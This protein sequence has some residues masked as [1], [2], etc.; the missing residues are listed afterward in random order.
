MNIEK[1]Q[2]ILQRA[3]KRFKEVQDAESYTRE[4]M[5]KDIDAFYADLWE[6]VAPGWRANFEGY[7]RPVLETGLLNPLVRRVSND[8]LSMEPEIKSYARNQE[9][10]KKAEYRQGL[11]RHI[12]YNSDAQ[13]AINVAVKSAAICGRGHFRLLTDYVDNETA[14]QSI[15]FEPIKNSMN[16]YMSPRRKGYDYT[17]CEYAF[18][19]DR[20]AKDEFKET[21]P[22]AN[23]MNWESNEVNGWYSSDDLMIAEYFECD[24]IN[25]TILFY[26]DGSKLFLDEVE[27]EKREEAK[28]L[29]EQTRDVKYKIVKW[30]K[31]TGNSILEQKTIIGDKIPI[32]TIIAD[33]GETST[34]QMVISGLVRKAKSSAWLYDLDCSLEAEVLN[35]NSITHW[36]ADPDQIAGAEHLYAS[37]NKVPRSYLPAKTIIK[38][39]ILVPRP[40]RVQPVPVSSALYSAKMS[41]KADMYASSGISEERMGYESN[42]QSGRAV[43]ARS[44][45]SKMTNSN[46]TRSVNKALTYAGKIINKWIPFTHD[47]N[48]IIQILDIENKPGVIE[49]NGRGEKSI[50]L[51][52][53]YDDIVITMGAGY[54]TSRME[55]M[56]GM[57]KFLQVSPATAPIISDLI[58]ENS[59]WPSSQKIAERIRSQMS[60]EVLNAGEDNTENTVMQN[61]QMAMQLQQA[62]QIMQQMQEEISRLQNEANNN[63]VK[64]R[65]EE[66]QSQNA[67]MLQELK[68]QQELMLKKMD[69]DNSIKTELIKGDVAIQKQMSQF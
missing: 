18:I 55:A 62:Q 5:R 69:N 13:E 38:N 61:K 29:A 49:I 32:C 11:I 46:I 33:E 30:Y 28:V 57:L 56:E 1:E 41:H 4:L 40:E 34:G 14:D 68:G 64:I 15:F 51:G 66:M 22:D 23:P 12:M 59:D 45:E 36:I 50:D 53:P 60:P 19:V 2:E 48:R 8:I 47:T 9:D 27:K 31:M 52:D 39:G 35:Q 58:A 6:A 37:A 3:H 24:Y 17:D 26:E 44:Q 63:A 42:A 16:V 20:I 10:K 65:L 7:D 54:I 43:L 21:Y 25:R 67:L